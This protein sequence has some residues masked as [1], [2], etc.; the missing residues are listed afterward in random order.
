MKHKC[1]DCKWFK[2]AKLTMCGDCCASVAIPAQCLCDIEW[3]KRI[4]SVWK[5]HAEQMPF[6]KSL[7]TDCQCFK[8]RARSKS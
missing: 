2:D 6:S 4:P 8:A 5:L 7:K 1:G 3:P